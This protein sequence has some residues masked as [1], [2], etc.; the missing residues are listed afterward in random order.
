[1]SLEAATKLVRVGRP[2][3]E[4][5][6]PLNPPIVPASTY[7]AGGRSE[8]GRFGNPTWSAFEAAIGALEG[9]Q[10]CAF[11]SGMAAA[12]AALSLLPRDA[13]VVAPADVYSGTL[14]VFHQRGH[15]RLVDIS[16]TDAVLRAL[17]GAACLWIESP[18]NPGLGIA[19]IPELCVAA[20]RAGALVVADN[21]FATP[22]AQRPLEVGADV[23]LH[24][25]TKFLAGHADL[26]LGV[27]ITARD[28]LHE[29]LLA[30]RSGHGSVPGTFDAWL[31]LRGLRTLHLRIER[32]CANAG[33][34]AYRLQQHPGVHRVRYPGLASHP[35][36]ERA[37][38]ILDNHG[39][40]IGVEVDG[41]ADA[42][43]RVVAGTRLWT[44]ATSLGGVESTLERRRRWAAESSVTPDNLLRLSVGVEDVED[45]WA[46]LDQSLRL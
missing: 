25:A 41:D 9:G 22:L 28:E 31:A 17:P 33:T 32:A 6:A 29:K 36:H 15:T 5:D 44:S 35:Q 12:H 11:G 24:S 13:V 14:G 40:I 8:Y 2:A 42:A 37:K 39:A 43:D 7:V 45:L 10:G 30:H 34:L 23:V 38:R 46:D 3:E 4:P 16:D 26:L 27:T 20:H 18:T 1:M 19:D 21:T